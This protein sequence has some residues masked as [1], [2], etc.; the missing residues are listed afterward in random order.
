MHDLGKWADKLTHVPPDSPS[1]LR[2]FRAGRVLVIV[3]PPN[4]VFG[5]ELPSLEQMIL[6]G[7]TEGGMAGCSDGSVEDNITSV[8]KEFG[9]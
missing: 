9:Y 2:K 8:L 4:I 3:A 7:Y 5:C 6:L 1:G